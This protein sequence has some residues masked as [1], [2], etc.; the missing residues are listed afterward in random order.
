M[1]RPLQ[2]TSRSEGRQAALEPE[3]L[4]VAGACQSIAK[5]VYIRAALFK[6]LAFDGYLE[7]CCADSPCKTETVACGYDVMIEQPEVLTA[8]VEKF[9]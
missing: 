4:N 2:R 1:N 6:M 9:A 5:R 8:I 3:K 7:Q